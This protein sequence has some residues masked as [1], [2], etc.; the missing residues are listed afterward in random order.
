[1][2]VYVIKLSPLFPVMVRYRLLL[3]CLGW[4]SRLLRPCSGRIGFRCSISGF[5][6]M[7][8][9]AMFRR[10]LRFDEATSDFPSA[11]VA[12]PL[13]TFID[14]T[15][16]ARKFLLV[17]QIATRAWPGRRARDDFPMDVKWSAGSAHWFE[18]LPDDCIIPG[19]PVII[20]WEGADQVIDD[21]CQ[22]VNSIG[23]YAQQPPFA[24]DGCSDCGDCEQQLTPEACGTHERSHDGDVHDNGYRHTSSAA[25]DV[26]DKST[27]EPEAS[28]DVDE[29]FRQ[30]VI[31]GDDCEQRRGSNHMRYQII[32]RIRDGRANRLA[33]FVRDGEITFSDGHI[34]SDDGDAL[35][36]IKS[37][38]KPGRVE[39]FKVV[40][41][42]STTLRAG[43]DN[44]GDLVTACAS[45][46][47]RQWRRRV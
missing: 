33:R 29:R 41:T 21:G 22:Y 25:F 15:Y 28:H 20:K 44:Y 26:G 38:E 30:H 35:S 42:V 3:P 31:D 23:V 46:K 7:D 47:S 6:I 10:V 40:G 4:R 9:T 11:K 18:N 43:D 34:S 39:G 36:H 2:V 1:M 8:R 19:L 24:N 32:A 17:C 16:M 37:G 14:K 5:T 12:L 13:L 27:D 45:S